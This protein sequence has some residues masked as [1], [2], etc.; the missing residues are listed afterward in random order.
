MTKTIIKKNIDL[1]FEFDDYVARHPDLL[2]KIPNKAY[3]VVTVEGDDKFNAYA[4]SL[5]RDPKRKNIVEAHKSADDW[6]VRPLQ[7][8]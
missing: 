3:V 8:A 6:T 4:I 5:V 1:G 2:D 7:L